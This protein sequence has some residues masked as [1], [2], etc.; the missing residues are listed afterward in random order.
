MGRRH[1]HGDP[2]VADHLAEASCR[3]ESGMNHPR[4]SLKMVDPARHSRE[5]M[6]KEPEPFVPARRLYPKWEASAAGATEDRLTTTTRRRLDSCPERGRACV[7]ARPASSTP[8]VRRSTPSTPSERQCPT[9]AGEQDNDPVRQQPTPMGSHRLPARCRRHVR[10]PVPDNLGGG[11]APQVEGTVEARGRRRCSMGAGIPGAAGYRS[12]PQSAPQ[13]RHISPQDHIEGGAVIC[14]T[15]AGCQTRPGETVTL[16]RVRREDNL[17]GPTI[18]PGGPADVPPP[19][20]VPRGGLLSE[21]SVADAAGKRLFDTDRGMRHYPD[22]ADTLLG[23]TLW[24]PEPSP[25]PS[26][27]R[28]PMRAQTPGLPVEAF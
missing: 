25:E 24:C 11:I 21:A 23:G 16:H 1:F 26:P 17:F 13:R 19:M 20:P 8:S 12:R 2:R 18:N 5:E 10:P 22:M 28:T 15:Q 6:R 3:V 4:P 27:A 9:D 7:C 14:N